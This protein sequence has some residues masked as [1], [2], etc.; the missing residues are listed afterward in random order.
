MQIK[1]LWTSDTGVDLTLDK[2]HS[3]LKEANG[4]K[5]RGEYWVEEML[6]LVPNHIIGTVK[7]PGSEILW[8]LI[9]FPT[10][11]LMLLCDYVIPG[12][13]AEEHIRY[14]K[15]PPY[16]SYPIPVNLIYF[17]PELRTFLLFVLNCVLCIYLMNVGLSFQTL[18]SVLF[19]CWTWFYKNQI[20][21]CQNS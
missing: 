9:Y 3:A 16:M 18:K 8:R 13:W 1:E 2:A 15:L 10:L 5:R 12:G 20:F 21:Q 17:Q 11:W 6:E 14:L 7:M 19:Y 4:R